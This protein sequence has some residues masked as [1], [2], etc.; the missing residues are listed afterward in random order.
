MTARMKTYKN[1][2]FRCSA[3]QRRLTDEDYVNKFQSPRL[4]SLRQ[5]LTSLSMLTLI[6]MPS[7]FCLMLTAKQDNLT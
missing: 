5:I 7:R 6:A 1:M 4:Q 2:I 3:A